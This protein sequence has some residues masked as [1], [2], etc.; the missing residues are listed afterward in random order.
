M[1]TDTSFRLYPAPVPIEEGVRCAEDETYFYELWKMLFNWRLI[2]R[3]KKDPWSWD[4]GWCY[5]GQ[6]E[7]AASLHVW[8]PE[9]Q[10][11]PIGWKKRATRDVIRRAPRRNEDPEYNR[12]RCVHGDYP[13]DGQCSKDKYC[14]RY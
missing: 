8:N 12:V 11:E 7:A 10:D 5:D 3:P 13:E 9:I 14:G 4:Y 2:V 1:P 6:L